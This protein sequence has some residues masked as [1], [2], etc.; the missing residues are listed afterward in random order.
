MEIP[1]NHYK[2]EEYLG[3]NL[4]KKELY[5]LHSYK[6][7]QIMNNNI[8]KLHIL[9]EKKNLYIPKL[10]N[11]NG[12]CLFESLN[13]H[14]IGYDT[15]T[16]RTKLSRLLYTF[17]DKKGLFPGRPNESL[18]EIFTPINS[19]DNVICNNKLCKYTYNIMCKDLSN[20]NS[21][22]NLEPNFILL[23]V[24]FL[25]K[26]KIKIIWHDT[27]YETILNAYENCSNMIDNMKT[28]YLGN[29]TDHHYVPLDMIT[30]INYQNNY[31]FYDNSK[32][33]FIKWLNQ[34][35]KID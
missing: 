30:D 19:I 1:I 18:K 28:I 34:I 31:L 25:Y 23:F 16:L 13:Y 10:T 4:N 15:Q 7:E 24:S 2:L 35:K 14:N 8:K 9:C 11:T 26:V 27:E 29:I 32:N 3:R 6:I 5:I 17:Q 33:I 20:N 21:W 12:N 22:N